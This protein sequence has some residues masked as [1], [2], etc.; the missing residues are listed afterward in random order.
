[1]ASPSLCPKNVNLFH[2]VVVAPF[3]GYIAAAHL[4]PDRVPMPPH[5]VYYVLALMTAMVFM[6]HG[7]QYYMKSK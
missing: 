1:M 4:Y 3:L 7:N 2:L 5:W 6:Y